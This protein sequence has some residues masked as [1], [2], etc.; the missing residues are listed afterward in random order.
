MITK[1]QKR[2][3][4]GKYGKAYTKAYTRSMRSYDEQSEARA[5]AGRLKDE[6]RTLR[7]RAFVQA[8]VKCTREVTDQYTLLRKYEERLDY[9]TLESRERMFEEGKGVR[10]RKHGKRGSELKYSSSSASNHLSLN[11]SK[12]VFDK[13]R[14]GE[15]AHAKRISKRLMQEMFKVY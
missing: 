15:R 4:E 13:F 12:P 2:E 7:E 3:M 6:R 1:N 10:F 5:K 14:K 9:H 11:A 8:A